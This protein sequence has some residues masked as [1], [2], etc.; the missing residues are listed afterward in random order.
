M[1]R[2]TPRFFA[3]SSRFMF[4]AAFC[5]LASCCGVSGL[6]SSKK[7]L[8]SGVLPSS[9]TSD[10]SMLMCRHAGLSAAL[11][12]AVDVGHRRPA[13]PRLAARRQLDVDAAFR[14]AAEAA[15]AARALAAEAKHRIGALEQ[16]GVVLDELAQADV[17]ALFVALGDDDQ[18]HRQLAV[19]GLD[20]AERVQL[21]HLRA[22]R[23]GGAAAEQHLLVGAPARRSA[24]SN[25]GSCQA[26]GC[27]TGIVSYI[28]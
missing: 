25:G 21:R 17:H 20:R 5:K 3:A 6:M 24:P 18:V 8:M 16:L 2:A 10:A 22:L 4:L 1:K 14:A 26:S 11:V 15:A 7:P 27:V 9:L 28:Q 19:H 13:A 23:V 12:G